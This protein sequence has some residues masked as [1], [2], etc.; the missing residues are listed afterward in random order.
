MQPLSKV[1]R[2]GAIILCCILS[3]AILIPPVPSEAN[4]EEKVSFLDLALLISVVLFSISVILFKEKRTIF[5]LCHYSI[6][7]FGL[8]AYTICLVADL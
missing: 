5:K 8:L 4:S 2:I 3:F 1:L 7:R 6:V